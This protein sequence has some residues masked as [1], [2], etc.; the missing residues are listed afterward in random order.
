MC[1]YFLILYTYT[2][3]LCFMNYV[4]D[5]DI[6]I[7]PYQIVYSLQ[8][9][10]RGNP[11][12]TLWTFVPLPSFPQKNRC[13][14]CHAQERKAIAWLGRSLE[15]PEI[16]QWISFANAVVLQRFMYTE[17]WNGM[18][19]WKRWRKSQ[20]RQFCGWYF[21]GMETSHQHPSLLGCCSCFEGTAWT[22][23][24]I[25]DRIIQNEQNC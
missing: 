5:D 16:E 18:K 8:Y 4:F 21:S 1:M 23:Y 20:L 14:V 13:I 17:A 24:P 3:Y 9:I 7:Y 25:G 10:W 22:E 11:R 6:L 2:L 12:Y 19:F 15:L